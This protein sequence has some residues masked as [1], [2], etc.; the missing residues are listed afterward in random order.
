ME[1]VIATVDS[2]ERERLEAWV[3]L[4]LTRAFTRF[5]GD[6]RRVVVGFTHRPGGTTSIHVRV[7]VADQDLH[8]MLRGAAA[9]TVVRRAI[10]LARRKTSRFLRHQHLPLPS[11]AAG[12]FEELHP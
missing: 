3:R 12:A 4:H 9:L 5:E 11:L 7:S 6:V 10:D 8:V 1:L 2:P